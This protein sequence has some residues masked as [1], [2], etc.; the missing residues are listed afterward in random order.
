MLMKSMNDMSETFRILEM[1]MACV[2]VCVCVCVQA[3]ARLVKDSAR[4]PIAARPTQPLKSLPSRHSGE[5][6]VAL[7][8]G[9][10]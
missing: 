3:P 4:L 5:L 2:C 6:P 7:P 1:F 8:Q 9:S 10:E